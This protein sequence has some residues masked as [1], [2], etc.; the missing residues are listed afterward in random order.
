MFFA[1]VPEA[2]VHEDRDA[3]LGENEVGASGDFGVAA[4]A[5]DFVFAEK[6]DEDEFGGFVAAG[7]DGTHDL[8]AF[9]F[10]ECVGHGLIM[11]EEKKFR[12]HFIGAVEELPDARFVAVAF[13]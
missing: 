5:G 6:A 1:A 7:A 12:S 11:N 10:G 8:G 9:G 13:D 4:P 3:L 2:A